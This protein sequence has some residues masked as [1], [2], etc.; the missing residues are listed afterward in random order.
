A[1][2]NGTVWPW[3][4]GPFIKAFLKVRKYQSEYCS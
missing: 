3:L 2:H 1:Y 4:L